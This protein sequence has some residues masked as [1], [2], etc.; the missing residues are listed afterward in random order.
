MERLLRV[1]RSRPCNCEFDLQNHDM[2]VRL[3]ML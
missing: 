1:P 3:I 2:D